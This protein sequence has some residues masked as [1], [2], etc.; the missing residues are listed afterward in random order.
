MTRLHTILLFLV[1][2][3]VITLTPTT[4]D[5]I[6]ECGFDQLELL[7]MRQRSWFNGETGHWL[8]GVI[9]WGFVSD[10]KDDSVNEENVIHTDEITGL[11]KSDVETIKNAMKQI[12]SK[13]CIRFK[14]EKPLSGQPWLFISRNSRG[15]RMPCEK[16]YIQNNLVGKNIS[17]FG[18]IY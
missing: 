17:G 4:R 1:N 9:T 10:G 8:N 11:T 12:E 14:N 2:V 3:K 7:E 15:R 18:D 6:L 13:T 16:P 5:Q